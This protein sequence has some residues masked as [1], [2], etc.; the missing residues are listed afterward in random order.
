MPTVGTGNDMV[1]FAYD[2][3]GIKAAEKY[4]QA[5]GQTV[6]YSEQSSQQAGLKSNISLGYKKGGKVPSKVP[7]LDARGRSG[8]YQMGGKIKKPK[9]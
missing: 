2:E 5:T 6:D 1:E 9:K 7:S 8:K 4:A 3:M